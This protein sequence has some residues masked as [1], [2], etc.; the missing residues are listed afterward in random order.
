MELKKV[1]RYLIRQEKAALIWHDAQRKSLQ[2]TGFIISAHFSEKWHAVFPSRQSC[3]LCPK[4]FQGQHSIRGLGSNR[5]ATQCN[6]WFLGTISNKSIT[7]WL[8]VTE[9][10]YTANAQQ[11]CTQEPFSD[12]YPPLPLVHC[13]QH[14]GLIHHFQCITSSEQTQ[15]GL[16]FKVPRA[17][18]QRQTRINAWV[19]RLTECT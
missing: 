8:S 2:L 12:G 13:D 5:T 9:S 7:H 6:N 10:L 14:T 15:R 19:V 3:F 1:L 16:P 18:T 4:P 11:T 17:W